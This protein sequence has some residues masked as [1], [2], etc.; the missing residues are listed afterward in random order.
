MTVSAGFLFYVALYRL[1]VLA[2]GALS[3]WLGFRLFNKVGSKT[4]DSAGSV[5]AEGNGFK[6]NLTSIL[7][8]AA[9]H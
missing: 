3:I 6:L 7:P 5:S 4:D 2:V 9:L 1:T 8:G